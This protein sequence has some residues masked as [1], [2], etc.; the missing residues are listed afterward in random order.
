MVGDA[1]LDSTPSDLLGTVIIIGLV[2]LGIMWAV[3]IANTEHKPERFIDGMGA[4]GTGSG[5]EF[6]VDVL[7]EILRPTGAA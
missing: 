1:V 7:R 4:I 6:P 2:W 3:S 5:M